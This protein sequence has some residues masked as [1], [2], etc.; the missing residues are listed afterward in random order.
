MNKTTLP[1]HSAT[2]FKQARTGAL[3]A[4]T[5][6]YGTSSRGYAAVQRAWLR[7]M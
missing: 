6:L 4:A 2:G 5:N 1:E 3:K 7:P